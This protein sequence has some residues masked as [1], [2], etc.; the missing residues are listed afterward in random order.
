M[1]CSLMA[2][3]SHG[4]FCK[5]SGVQTC[6]SYISF[7]CLMCRTWAVLHHSLGTSFSAESSRA[8][9][10]FCL[11]FLARLLPPQGS[12]AGNGCEQLPTLFQLCN[13][14]ARPLLIS[15]DWWKRTADAVQWKKHNWMHVWKEG[16]Y[17]NA[18]VKDLILINRFMVH[19]VHN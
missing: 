14:V 8:W 18:I 19:W 12:W 13:G 5:P 17:K 1:S 3:E 4:P 6:C 11:A 7:S 16:C 10:R 9:C 2:I 15:C